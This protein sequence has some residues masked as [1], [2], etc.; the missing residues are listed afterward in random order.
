MASSSVGI[1]RSG[2]PE[3]EERHGPGD[4]TVGM[5]AVPV[6]NV[7]P[8]LHAARL[9]TLCPMGNGHGAVLG[10][11]YHYADFDGLGPGI[12]LA[13]ARAFCRAWCLGAGSGRAAHAAADRAG[14]PGS[15]GSLPS[16]HR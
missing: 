2:L 13:R 14:M 10:R 3:E 15:L 12:A 11:A 9:G 5:V 7:Y 4:A 1:D 16:G 8:G 6:E